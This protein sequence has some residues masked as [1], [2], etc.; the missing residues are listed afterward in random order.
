MKHLD[1]EFYLG[2]IS[3][4]LLGLASNLLASLLLASSIL[5]YIF[6]YT[7][8]LKRRTYYNIVIGGA[9][10][11]LPPLIGWVSVS[12]GINSF[13]VILFLLIFIWT[14]PHFWA[15]SLFQKMTTEK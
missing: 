3:V 4:L 2:I 1:L 11:A 13:P 10:G 14:P 7:I 8:W 6:I 5:F 15:L 12:G 9:A